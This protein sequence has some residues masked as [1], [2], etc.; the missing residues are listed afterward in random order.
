MLTAICWAPLLALSLL[1]GFAVRGAKI[2]FFYDIGTQVRLLVAVPVLVLAEIPIGRGL[3]EAAGR[4]L[5]THLVRE[6]DYAS[7]NQIFVEAL[8]RRDSRLAEIIC[9]GLVYVA[10]TLVILVAP[11]ESGSTW[12]RPGT[13]K[14]LSLA[15]YWYA[16]VA[17]PIFQFLMLRW[18]YRLG[19]W[20]GALRKISKLD[21]ALTPTHP[22]RA[23]GLG[24][25][26]RALPPFGIILF[27]I[28]S[29]TSATIATRIL[30][31]GETL[32]EYQWS[33][34]AAFVILVAILSA[35][36][37]V[38]APRLLALKERGLHQYGELA[39]TYNQAF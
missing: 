31:E 22:D 13:Y 18:I 30:F 32:Q 8:K 26:G 16:L 35:P 14:G 6:K 23:G 12:I 15:G 11:Y 39:S 17:L 21:L 24:F 7:F 5:S 27:A 20:A 33:Y 28:S 36:M 9:I 38:F 29:V 4:F 3:R 34:L 37:L 1:G 25:L 2:P 10:S 19:I